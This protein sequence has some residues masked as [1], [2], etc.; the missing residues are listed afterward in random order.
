MDWRV[1]TELRLASRYSGLEQSYLR[2]GPMLW[3]T[4][5]LFVGTHI[6]AWGTAQSGAMA[7]SFSLQ[8]EVRWDLEPT[9]FGR[10]GPVTLS[11]RNRVEY[12]WFNNAAPRWR[13]RSQL[14]VNLAPQ[15]W[16]VMPFIQD[17]PLIDL[18]GDGLNQ[19]WTHVGVGIQLQPNVRLDLAYMNRQRAVAGAQDWAIDH[20]G[21]VSLFVDI[22]PATPSSL[23]ATDANN[24]ARSTAIPTPQ[25]AVVH[26]SD[27]ADRR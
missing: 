4:P 1:V 26:S 27:A 15:D 16:V 2:A 25:P 18:S 22:A 9:F 6:S 19:N 5:W 20:I 12:R 3:L 21:W 24:A 11:S 14:R 23:S 7:G 10:L 17:E 8:T 13:F